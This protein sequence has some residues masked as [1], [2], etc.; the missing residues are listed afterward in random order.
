[1]QERSPNQV[2]YLAGPEPVFLAA[3]GLI[4]TSACDMDLYHGLVVRHRST[5]RMP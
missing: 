3:V 5:S 2:H 4:R 1:M